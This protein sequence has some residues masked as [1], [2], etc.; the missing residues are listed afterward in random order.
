VVVE[1]SELA[2]SGERDYSNYMGQTTL[3]VV[4]IGNSRGV[5]LPARVLRRYRIGDAV[6]MDERSDGLLLRPA[7][8]GQRKLSWEDTAREMAA[9]REDWSE[10]D[11]A[12]A[13]GLEDLPWHGRRMPRVAESPP[14]YGPG[15]RQRR[16]R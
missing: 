12:A 4:R 3:K 5:R 14:P 8:P 9:S 11:A 1:G 13:D 15:S 6:V 7:G 16:R 2:G 10:W